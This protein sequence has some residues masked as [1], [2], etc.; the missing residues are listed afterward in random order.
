MRTARI[1]TT[2]IAQCI[3]YQANHLYDKETYLNSFSYIQNNYKAV[4][5]LFFPISFLNKH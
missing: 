5:V 2:L 4:D 1:T 3:V